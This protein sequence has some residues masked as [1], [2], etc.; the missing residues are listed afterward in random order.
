MQIIVM[1]W[2]Q[3]SR[4]RFILRSLVQSEWKNVGH[5]DVKQRGAA[6]WHMDLF[7]QGGVILKLSAGTCAAVFV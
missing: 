7:P 4:N 2:G 3:M 6:C 5:W 1:K